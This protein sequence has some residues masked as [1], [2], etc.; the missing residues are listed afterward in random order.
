MRRITL[1]TETTG[2]DPNSG[3][4]II[5]IG[6]VELNDKIPSGK[7][8][9]KYINPKRNIPEEALKIHG[10]SEKFLSDKP[11]FKEVVDDFLDFI[12]DSEL[13]IHNA[14]FDMGF[15]NSELTNINYSL[16]TNMKIIDTLKVAKLK[17][18]G[19]PVSLNSLCRRFGIDLS[20][21]IKHGAL[22]D[23]ELLAEVYLELSGGRQRGLN[24]VE[25]KETKKDLKK[26][27]QNINK[28][29]NYKR[30]EFS[31]NEKE[32]EAHEKMIKKINNPI[33]KM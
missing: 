8:W 21:R 31:I 25:N 6:C 30:R 24:L 9:H 5:E 27:N 12:K 22:L 13:I 14:K 10:I 11:V 3:H 16:I 17:F 19:S 29:I 32:L 20:K 15:I 18:P 33:W 23:A 26:L 4:K 28:T 1:D 2:L 7:T